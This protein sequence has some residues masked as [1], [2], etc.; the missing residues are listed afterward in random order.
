[1]KKYLLICLLPIFTTAC[2]AK[3]TPQEELD[4]QATFLPT[5]FNLD[6][7][8]YALAQKEAPTALTKQLYD[9]ALFKLGLLKRYDDQASENFK[10]E[11]TVEPIKLNTLCLMIKFVNNPTYIKAVKHSI[12]QEPDLNKWLKEKQPEWQ[13]ALKKEDKEIFDHACL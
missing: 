12:E 2:S 3:P 5:V 13:E 6:A 11:K 8:T 7:G 4:I 10:L 9:D 1:M